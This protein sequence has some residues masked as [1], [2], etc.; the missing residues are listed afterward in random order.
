MVTRDR[1]GDARTIPIGGIVPRS[2]L[3][4]LNRIPSGGLGPTRT[5]NRA[6][7]GR[8][9]TSWGPI[10]SEKLWGYTPN[11]TDPRRSQ[12]TGRAPTK[13][14]RACPS[15]GAEHQPKAQVT[16]MANPV[17][18]MA[19]PEPVSPP[20]LMLI[21]PMASAMGPGHC[22]HFRVT[23]CRAVARVKTAGAMPTLQPP[24]AP[25]PMRSSSVHSPLRSTAIPWKPVARSPPREAGGHPQRRHGPTTQSKACPAWADARQTGPPRGQ[26]TTRPTPGPPW[27]PNPPPSL[28][29]CNSGRGSPICKRR[30]WPTDSQMRAIPHHHEAGV[31]HNMG[32]ATR[33]HAQLGSRLGRVRM[34][35]VRWAVYPACRHHHRQAC[36]PW[37]VGHQRCAMDTQAPQHEQ[38][39]GREGH[40]APSHRLTG[41]KKPEHAER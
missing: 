20:E 8:S 9:S 29:K 32:V 19:M 16:H 1:H 14:P 41:M 24:W 40:N 18:A 4:R 6:T 23:C 36:S 26:D 28:T 35:L 3:D 27:V 10:R 12:W 30:P 33:T 31:V 13:A 11:H 37:S 17:Q 21:M 7:G 25:T 2:A 22:V 15:I 34:P 5:V 39:G 38:H